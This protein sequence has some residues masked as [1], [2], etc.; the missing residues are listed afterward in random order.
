MKNKLIF[1][2]AMIMVGIMQNSIANA[3]VENA[4]S[5]MLVQW[6]L[7]GKKRAL[8][9]TQDEHI[10]ALKN[11]ENKY[12]PVLERLFDQKIKTHLLNEQFK[13]L[14]RQFQEAQNNN[15][16][17]QAAFVGKILF[18]DYTDREMSILLGDLLINQLSE[19]QNCLKNENNS[20]EFCHNQGMFVL[21]ESG[22]FVLDSIGLEI[23][24]AV[25]PETAQ[26]PEQY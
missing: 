8:N 11:F 20:I 26:A 17:E 19:C 3:D 2:S 9:L 16:E 14:L 5:L 18:N 4:Q 21:L 24:N 12:K 25:N 6:A 13:I 7:A 22:N 10:A 1:L 23:L 15:D